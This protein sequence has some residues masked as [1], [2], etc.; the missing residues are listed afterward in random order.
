MA[1]MRRVLGSGLM[2]AA[3]MMG[4]ASQAE[5][6]RMWTFLNPEG[7]S[8]REVALAKI[9]TDFEAANP[10]IDV[11]VEPQ[12]WDQMTPKFLAAH[13]AGTAPDIIWVATDFLGDAIASGSLADLNQLFIKDWSDEKKASYKDANWDLTEIDGKQYGIF[14]SRNYIALLYRPDLL[15][16]AGIKIDD[17]KTWDDLRAASEKLTVKD[18]SGNVAR[19]GFSAAYSEQQP[20]PS[21][22]IPRIL[23][24]G[25]QLFDAEG[26]ANFANDAGIEAQDF[27]VS[28][29]ND[30]I[31]P[32]QAANWTVDDLFEQFAS[33]RVAMVQGSAV[34]VSGLQAKMGADKI[35]LALWPS[36]SGDKHDPG[37]VLGW[38]VGIW[39]GSK[40]Q[41]SASKFMDYMVGEPGDAIWAEVGGQIPGSTMTVAALPEFF[42]KPENQFLI[43]GAQGIREAGWLT[44]VAFSVGGFRQE[45]NKS[46][47]GMLINKKDAKTALT[48]A[49][50]AFNALHDR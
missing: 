39:S 31:S 48:E 30:G 37:V 18:A 1:K 27:F 12:V 25:E 15:A 13:G 4:T 33:D 41:E 8:P 19:Y 35:G 38:S 2:L 16:E 20:D 34:R 40:V 23:G 45:L 10:E 24:A 50:D 3:L 43:I 17:I 21:P 47:Q 36:E 32:A 7:Q 42:A 28:M 44:P 14:A 22:I 46:I 5:T 29:I 26:K 9:I 11:V 6:V 49:Q